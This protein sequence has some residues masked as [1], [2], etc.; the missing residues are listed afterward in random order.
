MDLQYLIIMYNVT[1]RYKITCGI[2]VKITFIMLINI[3]NNK[4][5]IYRER[6]LVKVI[7]IFENE[8]TNC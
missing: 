1:V 8:N 2:L 3:H 4:I 7:L 5:E 6:S